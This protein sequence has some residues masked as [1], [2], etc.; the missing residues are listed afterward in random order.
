M[1]EIEGNICPVLLG[2]TPV[3]TCHPDIIINSSFFHSQKCPG[4]DDKAYHYSSENAFSYCLS[5]F[6]ITAV[7]PHFTVSGG[8][9]IRLE[10]CLP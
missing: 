3:N 1:S 7:F 2:T 10:L 8:G 6:G 4:L 9:C 5:S